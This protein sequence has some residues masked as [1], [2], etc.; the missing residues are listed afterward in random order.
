MAVMGAETIY[1]NAKRNA[2]LFRIA[3]L[4]HKTVKE[5]IYIVLDKGLDV[6]ESE[7]RG[8]GKL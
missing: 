6:V 4:R 1:F 2:R 5:V 8:V 7:L 3:E